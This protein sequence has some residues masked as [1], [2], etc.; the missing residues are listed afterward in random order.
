M[1]QLIVAF[2]LGCLLSSVVVAVLAAL[3]Q[4]LADHIMAKLGVII[5]WIWAKLIGLIAVFRPAPKTP[6]PPPPAAQPPPAQPSA[7]SPPAAK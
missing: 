3:H 2:L 4:V 1:W 6:A 7:S 5:S